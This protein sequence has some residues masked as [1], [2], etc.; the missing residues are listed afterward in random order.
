MEPWGR[1]IEFEPS[2]HVVGLK[3]MAIEPMLWLKF[4]S[5]E[6]ARAFLVK[7]E[8]EEYDETVSHPLFWLPPEV[9]SR[10]RR[11][12]LIGQNCTKNL[13]LIMI[14]AF[15]D[16]TTGLWDVP[17]NWLSWSLR[18]NSRTA[19]FVPRYLIGSSSCR[20]LCTACQ[21]LKTWQGTG[22]WSRNL[23]SQPQNF[24]VCQ[25]IL[26]TTVCSTGAIGELLYQNVSLA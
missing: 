13:S 9:L 8:P 14:G 21:I 2:P 19:C 15:T 25:T 12:A 22:I 10:L 1:W 18:L 23:C 17:W 6:E 7:A 20:A 4:W 24:V 5:L 3:G 11:R 16:Q 26:T